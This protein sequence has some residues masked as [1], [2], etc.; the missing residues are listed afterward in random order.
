[1]FA[2]YIS[3]LH[4]SLFVTVFALI[5][6]PTHFSVAEIA[7]IEDS[8]LLSVL[9]S[10]LCIIEWY[11]LSLTT[12]INTL[13]WTLSALTLCRL[14]IEVCAETVK[15]VSLFLFY[16]GF[17]WARIWDLDSGLSV[18]KQEF[19]SLSETPTCLLET[20][21]TTNHKYNAWCFE[22][23]Y[24]LIEPYQNWIDLMENVQRSII[25]NLLPT[26]PGVNKYTFLVD[27]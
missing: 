6:T 27:F 10:V 26:S 22:T 20:E 19:C 13:K 17:G 25:N 4:V 24:F 14:F 9:L 8:R 15:H 12:Y 3:C 23:R 18:D 16:L 11:S 21:S 1:M 5:T 7:S 2:V